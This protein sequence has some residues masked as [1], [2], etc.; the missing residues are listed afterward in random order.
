MRL[1]SFLTKSLATSR[2]IKGLLIIVT[3]LYVI[4]FMAGWLMISMQLPFAIA[5]RNSILELVNT[6][7]PFTALFEFME[8]GRL[9]YA[10][11]LT[12]AVNLMSGAFIS[13]TLPGVIPFLGAL[14]IGT[15]T[16]YR[17]IMIGL[18]YPEVMSLSYETFIVAAGTMILELGAY[19]FSGAAGIN[20]ALAAI[21][22]KR[23]QVDSR[24]RAFKESCK[25]AAEIYVIVIILLALGAIWETTGLFLLIYST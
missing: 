22:P 6:E 8:S 13:T 3:A 24:W 25:E 18:T 12:F 23:H 19:V 21:F 7:Q 15:V 2:K 10:I 14:A 5:F 17:G 20:M 4:S 9:V 1:T 16:F 11:L